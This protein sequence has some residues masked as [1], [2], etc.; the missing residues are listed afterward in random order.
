MMDLE[1]FKRRCG[2]TLCGK[3]RLEELLGVGGMAAVYRGTHRNGHKVAV[4]VLHTV[5]SLDMDIRPRF[6]REG[7]V[8]NKVEHPGVVRVTDDD[9]AED[10]AAFLVMD[11]LEGETLKAHIAGRGGTLAVS[12]IV[13]LMCQLLE[14]LDAA[15]RKGIVHRD[16]KPDNLLLERKTGALKVLDFGIARMEGDHRAT[17]TGGMMGSPG[18]MSPEQACGHTK[19]M[20][21]QTDVWAVGAIFFRSLTGVPIFNGDTP[22]MIAI[23]TATMRPPRLGKLARGVDPKLCAIVDRALAP[24]KKERWPSADSMLKA[25]RAL[26]IH[27]SHRSPSVTPEPLAPGTN[28]P[29][30]RLLQNTHLAQEYDYTSQS[31]SELSVGVSTARPLMSESPAIPKRSPLFLGFAIGAAALVL[32]AAFAVVA[33]VTASK[34]AMP[35]SRSSASASDIAIPS[36]E[37][38]ALATGST[39]DAI[40]G[41]ASGSPLPSATI[42]LATRPPSSARPVPSAKPAASTPPAASA[43]PATSTLAT[44]TPPVA[45]VPPASSVPPA[46]AQ[47]AVNCNPNYELINGVKRFKKECPL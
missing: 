3:Y 20:D 16:I 32:L 19:L 13:P 21:G 5:L 42:S 36:A 30:S 35:S 23:Q 15:H 11:L 26:H 40:P 38:A 18:Y 14:V 1:A 12:E 9:I 17:R 46:P 43:Q 41:I 33:H 31:E 27:P 25:L 2:T 45:S 39:I 29:I 4:K 6:L 10:G 47:P 34:E 37:R 8:A 28:E 44:S 7:Y 24:D 22:E